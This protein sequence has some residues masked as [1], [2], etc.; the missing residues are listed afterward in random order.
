MVDTP[1]SSEQPHKGR[2]RTHGGQESQAAVQVTLH[3]LDGALHLHGNP[4]GGSNVGQQARLGLRSVQSAGRDEP[5]GAAHVQKRYAFRHGI[6]L[7]EAFTRSTVMRVHGPQGHCFEQQ[8][9]PA[10]H[11]HQQ[12][13]KQN[14][15]GNGI[16]RHPQG[17]HAVWAVQRRQAV[18]R[19]RV[20]GGL[21]PGHAVQQA[22]KYEVEVATGSFQHAVSR[23]FDRS[24]E[25]DLRASPGLPP[26][27]H[28]RAQS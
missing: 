6:S 8:D 14:R 3:G 15:F 7:P 11:T 24:G 4:F 2:Y 17:H 18:G 13:K 12:Q 26:A 9:V 28:C 20:G 10:T 5:Q 23:S 16:G 25:G 27:I 1:H 22:Q 21:R 19:G